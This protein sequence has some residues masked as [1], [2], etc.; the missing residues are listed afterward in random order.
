VTN[1]FRDAHH[2]ERNSGLGHQT[3]NGEERKSWTQ[4]AQKSKWED[5]PMEED[6]VPEFQATPKPPPAP[7]YT[8]EE[9]AAWK[10]QE[11]KNSYESWGE[12]SE[13]S[14]HEREQKAPPG[15]E[16]VVEHVVTVAEA[17]PVPVKGKG[18]GKHK[19]KEAPDKEHGDLWEKS[20]T[21]VGLKLIGEMAPASAR[22]NYILNDESRRSFGGFLPNPLEDETCDSYF[23]QI[24]DGVNWCQPEGKLGPI[25][26]KTAWMVAPGCTCTYTYGGIEVE[27]QDYPPWMISLMRTV[28]GCC[29]LHNPS[30]WPNC[31]NVNLYEDGGMSVG[32]HSDDESLFQGKFRDIT[33]ISLSLGVKRKFELRSNWPEAGERSLRPLVLSKGDLMTMEGMVQKHY[34]HRVPREE[35]VDGPRINLTWRWIVRHRHK[36]G[37]ARARPNAFTG[38]R[39]ES[40]EVPAE[41]AVET[42]QAAPTAFVANAEPLACTAPLAN[43]VLVPNLPPLTNPAYVSNSAPVLSMQAKTSAPRPPFSHPIGAGPGA[44]P[45]SFGSSPGCGQ[46]AGPRPSPNGGSFL[47]RPLATVPPGTS[48]IQKPALQAALCKSAAIPLVSDNMPAMMPQFQEEYQEEYQ[49]QFHMPFQEPFHEHFPDPSFL[50]NM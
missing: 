15:V 24:R 2:E 23:E 37:C 1:N 47:I 26:R 19:G 13:W 44:V 40:Q 3:R 5:A 28:M 49:E 10:K 30:E 33:I 43:P 18:K 39:Y 14:K 4:N 35:G 29:G 31:C 8:E 34:Q 17:P 25:P 22:W 36:C 32:W 21:E 9:W 42:S 20:R 6:L 45:P 50:G 12:W 11:Q 46:G 7:Q 27:P 48:E 41:V 16:P 38:V